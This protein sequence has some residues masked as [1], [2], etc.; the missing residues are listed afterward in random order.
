[1]DARSKWCVMCVCVCVCVRV[2]VCVCAC[3][4]ACVCVCVCVCVD[5]HTLYCKLLVVGGVWDH[6][7]CRF[8]SAAMHT[9]CIQQVSAW[10]LKETASHSLLL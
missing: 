7:V 9:H 10:L 8:F 2:C 6:I 5:V 3:V 4:R 1:M